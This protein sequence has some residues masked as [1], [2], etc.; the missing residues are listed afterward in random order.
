MQNKGIRTLSLFS[1]G[2]GLDIGF[3][4]AGGTNRITNL[5]FIGNK[6]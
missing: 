2:G 4:R 3:E 1:G 6:I 5:I